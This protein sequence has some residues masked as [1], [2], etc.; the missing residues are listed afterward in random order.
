[1]SQ[2]FQIFLQACKEGL[3]KAQQLLSSASTEEA[4][5]EAQ[6]AIEVNEE[7]VKATA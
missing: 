3:S 5:A 4:K 2:Y 1:M 6:I 7:L